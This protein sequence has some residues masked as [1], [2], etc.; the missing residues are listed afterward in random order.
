MEA[1]KKGVVRGVPVSSIISI[2]QGEKNGKG[3]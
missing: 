1:W 2:E 3:V